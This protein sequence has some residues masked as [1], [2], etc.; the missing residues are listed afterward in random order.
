MTIFT[1]NIHAEMSEQTEW[2]Q[3]QTAPKRLFSLDYQKAEISF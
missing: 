1:L 3:D 2:I